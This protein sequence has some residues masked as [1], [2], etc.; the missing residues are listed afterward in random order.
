MAAFP[1]PSSIYAKIFFSNLLPF[2]VIDQEDES[3]AGTSYL[4]RGM[5]VQMGSLSHLW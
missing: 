4:P 2:L 3:A 1:A 5:E